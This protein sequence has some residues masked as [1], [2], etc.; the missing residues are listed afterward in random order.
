MVTV[1]AKQTP[2]PKPKGNCFRKL[3]NL[4]P[5]FNWTFFFTVVH[6]LIRLLPVKLWLKFQIIYLQLNSRPWKHS[7]VKLFIEAP[8]GSIHWMSVRDHSLLFFMNRRVGS[9]RNDLGIEPILIFDLMKKDGRKNSNWSNRMCLR[10]KNHSQ[11]FRIPSIL[12]RSVC[13]LS[14]LRLK[15][16]SPSILIRL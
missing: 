10:E 11:C 13:M 14:I 5:R 15:M 2:D 3:F 7:P 9:I 4:R 8:S 12:S 6:I 16:N 1:R